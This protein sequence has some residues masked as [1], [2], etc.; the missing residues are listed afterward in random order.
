LRWISAIGPIYAF[1][2]DLATHIET[3]NTI[4][5]PRFS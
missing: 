3:E 1:T 2:D 5:F 4:L